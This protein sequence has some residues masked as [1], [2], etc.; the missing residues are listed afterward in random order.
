MGYCQRDPTHILNGDNFKHIISF[1]EIIDGQRFIM[2]I[3]SCNIIVVYHVI[4]SEKTYTATKNGPTFTNCIFDDP[5]NKLR[6]FFED[7][8]LD[9][10]QIYC[11]ITI[12]SPDSDY[13]DGYA[14]YNIHL[15][16][17]V[18]LEDYNYFLTIN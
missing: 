7:Y 11:D 13:P 1:N 8:T 18:I 10:G 15:D 6:V 3:S 2:D 9:N 4:G 16:L 14:N 12:E 5:T 17:N